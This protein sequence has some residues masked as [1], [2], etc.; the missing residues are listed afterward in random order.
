MMPESHADLACSIV[1]VHGLQGHPQK[2]WSCDSL[3]VPLSQSS[4]QANRSPSRGIRKIFSRKYKEEL[5]SAQ[6]SEANEVFWPLDLLPTDCTNARILTWGYDSQVSH[7]FGGPANQSNIIDHAKNLLR[8]LRIQRLNCQ[9][10][11]LIFVAHSL[12]GIIVKDV[13]HRAYEERKEPD[14]LEIFTSTEAILFLGTPHKGSNMAELG[15]TIRRIASVSGVDTTDQ[16]IRAL[17][18]NGGELRRIHEQFMKLYLDDQRHFE[19]LTFQEAKGMTGFSYLKMNQKVVETFSSSLTDTEPTQTINANHM[20]MCRFNGKDDEGYKQVLGE[21][22]ILLSKILKKRQYQALVAAA[23]IGKFKMDSSDQATTTSTAHSL[24]DVERKCVALLTQNT[25]DA[26]EY[27]STLPS[28][29]EG[30]CQWILSNSQYKEWNVQKSTCLLCINGYPGSGKTILSAYLLEYLTTGKFS[31]G[32][33]TTLCYFFCDEKIDTQRDGTAIL[34]S[35]IHQLVIQRR[36]LIKHV[37]KACDLHGPRLYQ[38]FN[39]LWRTFIA[40]ASDKRT[41]PISVIIDALDECE[42]NTRERF[43]QDIVKLEEKSRST[44]AKSPSIKFLITSRPP[45][46]HRYT[47]NILQIDPSQSHVEEDLKLVIQTKVE[48]I[49]K[50]TRCKPD[51]S[52]YLE[53]TLYSKADRTFLWVTLVLH[54]LERSFLATQKNFMRIIDELPTTLKA[55]YERFLSD[56]SMEYQPLA[57]K[58]LN[59]LVGSSRPLSLEEMRILIAI[60]SHH[61]TI[62]AVEEDAEPNMRE[63]LQG[64]LG[65]LVR[66]SES[67]SKIYLV[68]QSLKEFLEDLSNQPDNPLSTLYGVDFGKA[69]SLLAEACASY[70]LLEDFNE[71]LFSSDQIVNTYS[72]TSPVAMS[73][74]DADVEHLWDGYALGEDTL[75]KEP[76]ASET[77][78]CISIAARYALFEYG[79]RHWAEHF[80]E[81]SKSNAPASDLQKS[82]TTLS[83]GVQTQGMNWLR[84]YWNQAESETSLPMNFVPLLIASYF[85]HLTTVELILSKEPG[86]APDLGARAIY[87]ASRMGRNAVVDRLLREN[88]NPDL[89]IVTGQTALIAA[90]TLGHLAV[91][92]HFLEDDG[93]IPGQGGYRVNHAAI[94]GRTPL[95]IAASN[96]SVDIVRILL[97]HPQIQP[98]IVSSDHRTPLHWAV[99]GKYLDIVQML[100]TDNRIS[101]NRVDREGRNVLSL[102]AE[103]GDNEIVKYLI[104]FT[105]LR[106]DEPDNEGRTAFS[107]AAGAGHLETVRLLRRSCAIS[108]KSMPARIDIGKRDN[109]GRNP[110]SWACGAGHCNVVEYLIRH[111]RQGVDTADLDGWAPLA[112]ALFSHNP[113]VVR[114]LL[115]SGFVDVNKK[116]ANG[117]SPLSFA[118][119][120]G[121]LDVVKVL[122]SVEGIEVSSTN[123]RGWTPLSYAAN[124]PDI[125]KLLEEALQV[126]PE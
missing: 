93:A 50:R 67:E 61:R 114:L 126:G 36:S 68:H 37:K 62:A 111:N 14:L 106:A 47:T 99:C 2:T 105:Q 45:L 117:R 27:M 42:E 112:W 72:P 30:T 10:R 46:G 124:R 90:V 75:F 109:A 4:R 5:E 21:I 94:R 79:A 38:N 17:Q 110:L 97:Q 113:K 13:L 9:G 19:A 69:H 3:R 52:A 63:T 78:A 103:A 15:E 43:L 6:N 23:E 41:G 49:A 59:I 80:R 74:E 16:N 85:G 33:R 39:E 65:P 116:D 22:Q 73:P 1:F 115:D 66:I 91:V 122:L 60:Q 34:R 26:A 29:V 87:W 82:V 57:T 88:F 28:R 86:T 7:F 64:V 104:S 40:I 84:F 92:K 12:G 120:Y 24:N 76:E 53:A 55:T 56:I 35:I 95:S 32:L 31:P 108:T 119:D 71:D 89:E 123:D 118:V 18:I 25:A 121:Y 102:A 101:V 58:L 77:E 54:L 44:D 81:A 8:A 11:S 100:L 125:A 83:D 96:G 98:D 20:S 107:W 70:L 51:V 48:D